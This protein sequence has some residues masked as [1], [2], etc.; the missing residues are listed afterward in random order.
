VTID[1]DVDAMAEQVGLQ[2]EEVHDVISRLIRAGALIQNQGSWTIKDP[3]RLDEFL[4][5][6]KNKEQFR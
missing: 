2:V 4:E 1:G 3:G 5:F 6:L